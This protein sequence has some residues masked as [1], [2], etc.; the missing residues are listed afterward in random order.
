MHHLF[1]H[2]IF[3]LEQFQF[4]PHFFH[5]SLLFSL[6]GS[7]LSSGCT[8]SSISSINFLLGIPS[9]HFA[10]FCSN[11]SGCFLCDSQCSSGICGL[12][13]R[14]RSPLCRASATTAS[15]WLLGH[16]GILIKTLF[17]DCDGRQPP[18][19]LKGSKHEGYRFLIL[20]ISA[21]M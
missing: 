20:I 9:G 12:V 1:Q 14:T 2:C 17:L 11:V 21:K 16:S 5:S 19:I 8:A 3:C 15:R 10:G 6:F 7:G 13:R 18:R 4:P